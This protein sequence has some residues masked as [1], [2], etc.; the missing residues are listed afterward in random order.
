ME[1]IVRPHLLSTRDAE[2][3]E[4]PEGLTIAEMVA[5]YP[6]PPGVESQLCAL[7]NGHTV[8]REWW[9]RVRPR[10][11]AEITVA[12]ALRGGGGGGKQVLQLIAIVI[13]VIASQGA[14]LALAAEY[15]GVAAYYAAGITLVGNLA[16]SA[17]FKP[18][19][20]RANSGLGDRSNT[21][22]FQGQSN[23]VKPYGVIPRLLGRHR[24]YP[25]VVG[26]PFTTLLG[27]D[28]YI[29]TV[30]SFGYG[31][32]NLSDIKIGEDQLEL[33]HPETAIHKMFKAGDQLKI[34]TADVVQDPLALTLAYNVPALFS[35]RTETDSATFDMNFFQ[36][37]GT[38]YR[39][40]GFIAWNTDTRVEYRKVGTEEW[41]PFQFAPSWEVSM[42]G[43]KR[44]VAMYLWQNDTEDPIPDVP[45]GAWFIAKG[46]TNLSF[47]WPADVVPAAGSMIEVGGH[48]YLATAYDDRFDIAFIT[49]AVPEH[50][51]VSSFWPSR[52]MMKSRWWNPGNNIWHITEARTQPFLASMTVRFPERAQWQFRVT[53]MEADGDPMTTAQKRTITSIKSARRTSPLAPDAPVTL[54]EVKVKATEQLSGVIS[55]L[56]A[57]ASAEI[58]G[59]NGTDWVMM[60]TSNPAWEY[61]ELLQGVAN[62]RPAPD[63]RIDWPA[64][65]AW[66]AYCDEI[67]PGFQG[68]TARCDFVVDKG[69]T[70]WEL[71]TSVATNG[72]A[73]PTMRDNKYSVIVDQKAPSPVQLFTPRNSWGLKSRRKYIEAPDA[74]RVKW[75]DP[76][77]GYNENQ[78]IVYNDGF[79][80][81]NAVA[82]EE[83]GLFGVTNWEQANRAGRIALARGKLQQ[84]E[85]TIQADIENIICV[86][87]DMVGIAHDVLE[88]GGWSARIATRAG[89][90]VTFDA[91]LKP[92]N[93]PLGARVRSD[94]G[95]LSGVLPMAPQGG[96]ASYLIAGLP[97]SAKVGDLVVYGTIGTVNGWYLVKGVQPG[98]DFT[99]EIT[100]IEYAPGIWDAETGPI[101]PYVP[102]GKSTGQINPGPVT[103]LTVS[104]NTYKDGRY[105]FAD[106]Y[107]QWNPPTGVSVPPETYSVSIVNPDGTLTEVGR[108]SGL[109][110]RPLVRVPT[111]STP[112]GDTVQTFDVSPLWPGIRGPGT[113]IQ[114]S[115]VL[116]T[117][118]PYPPLTG[119]TATP[120]NRGVLIQWAASTADALAYYVVRYGPAGATWDSTA[121]TEQKIKANRTDLPAT[122]LVGSYV[123]FVTQEDTYEIRSTPVAAAFTV[124]AP[125]IV[126]I[127]GTAVQNTTFL[128]W[129][130]LAA[131]E[132]GE[133][134][135]QTTFQIEY[136][137]VQKTRTG[138]TMGA[139]TVAEARARA[140][141]GERAPGSLLPEGTVLAGPAPTAGV[142]QLLG[143]YSAE[144]AVLNEQQEGLWEY[145]VSG[146]DIAGNAAPFNCVTLLVEAPDNYYLLDQVANLIPLPETTKTFAAN[147]AGT[148]LW[149]APVDTA[150]TWQ[151][152]FISETWDQPS[153]QTAAGFPI[154]V[155]PGA[156]QTSVFSWE[157]D[158][159]Q[160]LPSLRVTSAASHTAI[161]G[162]PSVV[163]VIYSKALAADPWLEIARGE[164]EA[165]SLLPP[166]TRYV[167]VQME[168]KTDAA[169]LGL[170]L[171]DGL[172]YRLDVRYRDD[173]GTVTTPASGVGTVTFNVPFLDV[174]S[175]QLTSADPAVA[176][177]RYQ[178]AAN[179][180]SM[181]VYTFN[182]TGTPTGGKVAW[183][184]QGI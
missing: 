105:N 20:I 15:G 57:I 145:C 77:I 109:E 153:D 149:I 161:A 49:P 171:L 37:L 133:W 168:T 26:A 90:V 25:D 94:N 156:G 118:T 34:Y 131:S 68:P 113:Q 154:Y 172:S 151:Q 66:G 9:A 10:A 167:R 162:A 1:I 73:M 59:W 70:L 32:V 140:S 135:A 31:P 30:Y 150:E 129:A 175:V 87:G 183:W 17:L 182:T 65:K 158:Y 91:P 146:V 125:R 144:F 27:K 52:G 103:T 45:P 141:R 155:Q 22:T 62:K 106:V 97:A 81:N 46:A 23:S 28:Q 121:A 71:L 79:D 136:Y 42:G 122:F 99:A 50:Y 143:K 21:Y 84:E 181:T 78:A 114:A 38:T 41:I 96:G 100:C 112:Y 6:W 104:V 63:S 101:P 184:A 51:V 24:V 54:L 64:I 60:E 47:F 16:L 33:Y 92:F 137:T 3:V 72:R 98:S 61:V 127:V 74:L 76:Q 163:V 117:P 2:S 40:E 35:T 148:D 142:P 108:T 83:L 39:K 128:R 164:I 102:Q 119:V 180:K 8:P 116:T 88:V 176:Y 157:H 95:Q 179:Q 173:S 159:A 75:I 69:Y 85:F 48:Q 89:E 93:A 19:P 169:R 139:D 123:A 44:D 11:G 132:P 170:A 130:N 80:V 12:V 174:R 67:T 120:H 36:G 55:N 53:Q 110:W 7:V 14:G 152:H 43:D 166:G 107:L 134:G 138:S 86:R 58:K 160:N 178:V 18:A 147:R 115:I 4:V 5:S 165:V 82:F 111:D 56:S 177:A 124:T 13:L 126:N 29:T